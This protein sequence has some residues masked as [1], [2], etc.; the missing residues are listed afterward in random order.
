MDPPDTCSRAAISRMCSPCRFERKKDE[1]MPGHWEKLPRQRL[2][3]LLRK[4]VPQSQRAEVWWEV[5]GCEA[6]RD[7]C[8]STFKEYLN[9]T[10]DAQTTEEILRDVPRTFPAHARFRT[11]EGMLDLRSVLHAYAQHSPHVGYCQGINFIA[12]MFLAVMKNREKAFWAL[13]CAVN[14]LG[15]E[16]YYTDSLALLRADMC[17]LELFLQKKASELARCLRMYDVD[18]TAICSEWFISWFATCLPVCT[19]L[20][21]WDSL[22]Y[23]GFKV[24]FRVS[25]G[26]FRRAEK[27]ALNLRVFE[28]IMV[29]AKMWPREEFKADELFK[30]SFQGIWFLRRRDLLRTRSVSVERIRQE[31]RQKFYNPMGSTESAQGRGCSG[32]A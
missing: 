19:V 5:L 27:E 1:A 28:D 3:K 23:E 25:L 14:F 2:K 21:V 12:A 31:R 7:K 26:I 15:C 4:G 13:V 30:A 6:Y 32:N 29:R 18:I 8:A 11:E 16:G 20:R 24:M 17:V 10:L 22:F 9:E